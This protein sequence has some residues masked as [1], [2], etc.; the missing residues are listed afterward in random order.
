MD[1]TSDSIRIGSVHRPRAD[2]L[3]AIGGDFLAFALGLTLFTASPPEGSGDLLRIPLF[4][5][6]VSYFDLTVGFSCLVLAWNFALRIEKHEKPLLGA[7]GLVILARVL[8]LVFASV[9]ASDQ[10]L[11]IFR[12]AS[13][14]LL[15]LLL[16]NL[17]KSPRRRRRFLTGLITGAAL[18][19]VGGL[20]VFIS[21]RGESRGFWLGL[22][23]NKLQVFLLVVCCLSLARKQYR[24][25]KIFLGLSLFMGIFVTEL[26]SAFILL[27]IALLLLSLSY[28]RRMLRPA[29]VL[30]LIGCLVSISLIQLMPGSETELNKRIQQIVTGEGSI[31]YRFILWEMAAVAY[32]NH[33]MTG[34]GSGGFSRQQNALYFQISDA[35]APEYEAL[36]LQ[37]ST[38]NTVLGVAAETGTI[39]LIAYFV[40]VTAVIR[41]CLS[42]IRKERA[43]HD[44][45]ILASCFLL[46]AMLTQDW[47]GQASFIPSS[48]CLLGLVLGWYRSCRPAT[49]GVPTAPRIVTIPR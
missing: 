41:I 45:Y 15:L 34:L 46:L 8:S 27:I 3:T 48:T 26:R 28:R 40:W 43:H 13:T 22:D 1:S 12:Y 42:A 18:E 16:A 9:V 24:W 38:H 37:L 6:F 36:G 19:T 5:Y 31:G 29:W 10:V 39:G 17:L 44:T 7:L 30:M 2:K 33:P 4:S 32:L 47:W 14:F 21:S 49:I 25:G 20:V 35:F 11:S 23:N